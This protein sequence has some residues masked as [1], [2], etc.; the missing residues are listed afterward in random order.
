[1]R[2]DE[3]E[4]GG[5]RRLEEAQG[6]RD[7][8]RCQPMCEQIIVPRPKNL[9]EKTYHE[10]NGWIYV[11][12]V[13]N[14][15]VMGE[16]NAFFISKEEYRPKVDGLALIPCPIRKATET[17]E[18][19]YGF[20]LRKEIPVLQKPHVPNSCLVASHGSRNLEKVME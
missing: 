14:D 9:G 5:R 18:C 6:R 16:V 13:S 8:S 10:D 20:L 1:M 7:E 15:G 12:S 3:E 2:D 4:G 17:K 19:V 11:K